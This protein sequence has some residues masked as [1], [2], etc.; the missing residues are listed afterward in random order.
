[1]VVKNFDAHQAVG[2]ARFEYIDGLRGLAAMMVVITHIAHAAAVKHPGIL[3]ASVETLADLGR[4]GVQIFFVLSGFVIAHSVSRGAH[5]FRYL[6]LFAGR[7]FVRL[8]L[9][10]WC[11]IALELVLLAISGLVMAQYARD[12]PSTGEIVANAMYLQVFLGYEHILPVFWTL[13]YEVQFYLAFVLA[14]VLLAKLREFGLSSRTTKQVATIALTAS[15]CLSLAIY[16]GQLPMPHQA[17]FF[18]RWF[19]FAFGV[20]TY[21]Y[22]RGRCSGAWIAAGTLACIAGAA[23]FGADGYRVISTLVTAATGLAILASLRFAWWNSLMVGPSMQFLGRISYSLYLIHT[24]IGWRTTVLARE[25]MGSAYSTAAA[26]LAFGLGVLASVVG[27][28]VMYL[29]IERPA[30]SIAR[31]IPLPQRP[32]YAG[33]TNP[34]SA[35]GS[36]RSSGVA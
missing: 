19:Q 36:V 21:L 1:M 27:A 13:C 7:R 14:L 9:P 15:F 16:L 4:H 2:A 11:I 12:L 24:S 6:G 5:S 10:Y 33:Q 34:V 18:D 32:T 20:A 29:L 23:A 25:M 3:G 17:L 26:Y 28:W 35:D 31:K 22:F 8:D 30:I